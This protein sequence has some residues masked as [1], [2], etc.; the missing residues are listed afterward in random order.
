[1]RIVLPW[2]SEHKWELF[3]SIWVIACLA[4]GLWMGVTGNTIGWFILYIGIGMVASFFLGGLHEMMWIVLLWP[5][6][7][8]A[9]VASIIRYK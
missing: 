4:G 7:L 3:A 2:V 9:L 1:M 8:L 6:F 5:L